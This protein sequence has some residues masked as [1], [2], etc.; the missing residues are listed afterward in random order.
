M[1]V[2]TNPAVAKFINKLQAMTQEQ[3]DA[4]AK[5]CLLVGDTWRP[6]PGN[7]PTPYAALTKDFRRA[8]AGGRGHVGMR[9][10]ML[11]EHA[12]D[13]AFAGCDLDHD[14]TV[15]VWLALNWVLKSWLAKD[16]LTQEKLDVLTSP[17]TNVMGPLNLD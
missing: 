9:D 12:V 8:V 13:D 5:E 10:S 15:T 7:K 1:K 6:E 2:A 3:A 14:K 11:L 17:W 4:V 16:Q